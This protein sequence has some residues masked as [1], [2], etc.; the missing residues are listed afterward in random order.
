M[1]KNLVKIVCALM[2]FLPLSNMYASTEDKVF[3]V[4][5]NFVLLEDSPLGVWVYSV[6]GADP[7]YSNGVL[8]IEEKEKETYKVFVQLKNGTLTGQDVEVDGNTVKFGMNIEGVERVVVELEVNGNLI[9]GEVYTSQGPLKI[10]GK[11][12]LPPK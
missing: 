4:F 1:K 5:D 9:R 11:R 7:E 10:E 8:Y 6:S 2:L 3:C 12:K